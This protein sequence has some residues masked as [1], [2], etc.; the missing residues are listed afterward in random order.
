M[1]EFHVKFRDRK[2]NI[3]SW[4]FRQ[5][6]DQ[7]LQDTPYSESIESGSYFSENDHSSYIDRVNSNSLS[8]SQSFSHDK[9]EDNT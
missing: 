2:N 5:P 1:R 7:D 4:R 6:N 9:N 3:E 8:Q